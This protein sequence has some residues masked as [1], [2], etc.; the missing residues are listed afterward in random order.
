MH[1]LDSILAIQGI[2][3]ADKEIH[4]PVFN[5]ARIEEPPFLRPTSSDLELHF[6]QTDLNNLV[7]HRKTELAA[8]S[9]DWID[10]ASLVLWESTGG[11]ISHRTATTM[12][13][14]VLD[15]YTSSD[16]HSK[17]LSFAVGFLK[18]LAKTKMSS[19]I[20]SVT[21]CWSTNIRSI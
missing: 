13:E 4:A 14:S 8:K 3:E 17:V 20:W 9:L 21:C 6:S 10:R 5:G 15:K 1:D 7:A 2:Q 12:W 11:E 19:R 16:S 18:F